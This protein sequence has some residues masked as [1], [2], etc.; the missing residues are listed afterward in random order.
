MPDVD[1]RIPFCVFVVGSSQKRKYHWVLSGYR[2]LL[3]NVDEPRDLSGSNICF[4]CSRM[5]TG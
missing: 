4:C 5:M 2:A 3:S 1:D